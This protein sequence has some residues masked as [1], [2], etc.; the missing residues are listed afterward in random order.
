MKDKAKKILGVIFLDRSYLAYFASNL[1][2]IA[3]FDLPPNIVRDLEIL[4]K[5]ELEIQLHL[6][7]KQIKINP[8]F[9]LIVLSDNTCFAKDFTEISAV[10]QDLL[11]Q[12][13]LNNIPFE[14]ISSKLYK[15]DR[16][17]R[18][19]A[20]NKDL[21]ENISEIFVKL[22]FVTLGVAPVFSLGLTITNFDLAA[23]KFI[24]DKHDLVK[25]QSFQLPQQ[26]IHQSHLPEK[27]VFGVRR[28]LILLFLFS[29]L[30]S[31]LLYVI[32]KQATEYSD[33]NNSNIYIKLALDNVFGT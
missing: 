19:I 20:T 7:V 30:L 26:F 23:A 14:N 17:F 9:L 27:K 18:I 31:V 33:I 25:Q 12:N 11:C 3:R 28:V 1:P 29:I 8:G 21:Y 13:F 5:T 6:F 22:G 32:Y 10:Q 15:I 2:N 4:N 24:L 16:G